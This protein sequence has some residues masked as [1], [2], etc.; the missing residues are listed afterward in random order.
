MDSNQRK[1]ISV[2]IPAYNESESLPM[3]YGRL[4]PVMDGMN[5]CD[6][7]MLVV[8]DGSS[9]STLKVVAGLREQDNR[10]N[11]VDMSRNYGK[12]VSML[13]GFDYATGDC[14]V[15]MDADLQHPPEVIPDFVRKWEEGYEDVYAIRKNRGEESWLRKRF[16]LLFYRILQKTTRVDVLQNVGDFRLLDRKCIDMLRQLRESERYTKG[17]YCWIGCRKIGVEFEQGDRQAGRSSWNFF[18]LLNLAVEGITSFTIAPLRL[19]TISGVLI[20]LCAFLYLLCVVVKAIVWGDPVAGY[21]SLMTVILFVGGIQ[22]LFLGIIGEYL[23]RVFNETK[24]RPVYFIA[25]YN[26]ER[27]AR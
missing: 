11:Y 22:L 10:V 17:M 8:N 15:I 24:R 4:L 1:K 3:L 20:A 13:A 9:D 26:G 16:T 14:A 5:G 12:E 6:W 21:P 18:S 23:G 27:H 2:I 25:S 19:A 7:E